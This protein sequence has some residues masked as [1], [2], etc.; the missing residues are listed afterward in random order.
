MAAERAVRP[1][2]HGA[3]PVERNPPVR[4]PVF[5]HHDRDGG[6]GGNNL[7]RERMYF[8]TL[9]LVIPTV[10]TYIRFIHFKFKLVFRLGAETDV[11]EREQGTF[12]IDVF[13]LHSLSLKKQNSNSNR[14]DGGPFIDPRIC[15]PPKNF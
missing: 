8:Y 12:V 13:V 14:R 7:L 10:T 15:T 9:L 1:A 5:L 11:A 6:R 3:D 4:G 2:Q